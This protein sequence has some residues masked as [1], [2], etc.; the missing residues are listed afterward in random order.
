VKEL[1][2]KI[3]RALSDLQTNRLCRPKRE[4]LSIRRIVGFSAFVVASILE[5]DWFHR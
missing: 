2:P 4:P 1:S 5:F 3:I